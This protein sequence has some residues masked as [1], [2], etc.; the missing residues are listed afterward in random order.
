M[1]T[2]EQFDLAVPHFLLPLPLGWRQGPVWVV[3]ARLPGRVAE[4]RWDL[5]RDGTWLGSRRQRDKANAAHHSVRAPAEEAR[6]GAAVGPLDAVRVDEKVLERVRIPI[7][8][9]FPLHSSHVQERTRVNVPAHR[10]VGLDLRRNEVR[11]SFFSASG[12][13]FLL[14]SFFA[15][16]FLRELRRAAKRGVCHT[17]SV[18]VFPDANRFSYN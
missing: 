5:E 3:H 14:S 8:A 9:R 18:H 16:P 12:G 6:E 4:D 15:G 7:A 17:P 1:R 11:S 10:E 2:H 13:G